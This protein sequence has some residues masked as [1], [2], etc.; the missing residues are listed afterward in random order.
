MS[1]KNIYTN[2]KIRFNK[3]SKKFK[4]NNYIIYIKNIFP[5][6][7]FEKIVDIT[8]NF[9]DSVKPDKFTKSRYGTFVPK[10]SE[11]YQIIYNEKTKSIF[12]KIVKQKLDICDFPIEYRIYDNE[13]NGMIWHKDVTLYSKPQYEFVYVIKN[14]SKSKTAFANKNK[15][16]YLKTEP[17]SLIIVRANGAPHKVTPN[18]VGDRHILKFILPVKNSKISK[19][20]INQQLKR[21]LD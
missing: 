3:L 10:E 5:E 16:K 12:E 17:N 7:I 19:K 18:K 6:E 14:S 9:K 21:Y 4:D 13:S 15:V 11:L 2:K 1:K 8:D 20:N